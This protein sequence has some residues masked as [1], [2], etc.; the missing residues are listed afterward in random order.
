MHPPPRHNKILFVFS[1]GHI[2]VLYGLLCSHPSNC[3][4]SLFLDTF[5]GLTGNLSKNQLRNRNKVY[6]RYIVILAVE[7]LLTIVYDKIRLIIWAIPRKGI[8]TLHT[9]FALF[10]SPG[11]LREE[12]RPHKMCGR[13]PKY[14]LLNL[15]NFTTLLVMVCK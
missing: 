3:G 7:L 9:I 13:S 2:C 5:L 12:C 1:G 11:I 14:S 10:W 8:Y 15:E 4:K 6:H